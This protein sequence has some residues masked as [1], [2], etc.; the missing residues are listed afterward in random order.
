MRRKHVDA[1]DLWGLGK[2][3]RQV[4]G[5]EIAATLGPLWFRRRWR[6]GCDTAGSSDAAAFVAAPSST[7]YWVGTLTLT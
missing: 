1:R 4:N 7:V 5:Q 2:R 6:R 3:P